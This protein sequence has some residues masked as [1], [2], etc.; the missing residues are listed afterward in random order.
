MQLPLFFNH[1]SLLRNFTIIHSS[2]DTQYGDSL[3]KFFFPHVH[4]QALYNLICVFASFVFP[5]IADDIHING[6]TQIVS[7]VEYFASSLALVGLTIQPHKC[8]TWSL[9]NLSSKFS[10]P[11]G[12]WIYKFM[13]LSI[14]KNKFILYYT[15]TQMQNIMTTFLLKPITQHS[16]SH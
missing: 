14:R 6:P 9:S 15:N 1:H 11:I 16:L 10:L 4:F 8:A 5:S 12:Y 2:I 13:I 3:G 7:H